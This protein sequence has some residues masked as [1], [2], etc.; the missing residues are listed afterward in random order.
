L[1]KNAVISPAQCPAPTGRLTRTETHAVFEWHVV[2]AG[3]GLEG[4]AWAA[5]THETHEEPQDCAAAAA[6]EKHLFEA[7]Q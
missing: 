4:G 2:G 5:A 1:V 6:V 3:V 7:G